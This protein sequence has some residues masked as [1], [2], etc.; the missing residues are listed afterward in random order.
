[1]A[2]DYLVSRL[3]G[4][5]IAG[6]LICTWSPAISV[7]VSAGLTTLYDFDSSVPQKGYAPR[8]QLASDSSGAFYGVTERGGPADIGTIF[9]L[10]KNA[11]GV[12]KHT[13]L[14]SFVAAQG[15]LPESGLSVGKDKAFYGTTP[16]GGKFGAGTIFRFAKTAKGWKLTVLHHFNAPAGEGFGNRGPLEFD[17]NGNIYGISTNSDGD[18]PGEGVVYQ[19]KKKARGGYTFKVLHAFTGGN[20]GKDSESGVTFGADG[21][22]YGTSS[23]STT[24]PG[25]I[26]K[27]TPNAAGT[28]WAHRVLH[29]FNAPANG[30]YPTGTLARDASGTLYGV[31]FSG[32]V[33]VSFVQRGVVFSYSEAEGFKVLYRFF[34]KPNDGFAPMPGPTLKGNFLYGTTTRGGATDDGVVYRVA[35]SNGNEVILHQMNGG[36]EGSS[37]RSPLLSKGGV[38]YGT[39]RSE[40]AKGGGSVFMFEP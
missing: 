18:N 23:G 25:T 31:T 15:G 12:W 39:L 16:R 40:G 30:R 6:A 34:S 32:G 35:K 3:V 5:A 20:G 28:K 8:G 9:M 36:A 38:F 7:A 11:K 14:Y 17:K 21:E 26:F 19:L 29:R 10:K 24:T 37:S 33:E 1:M 4:F 2:L 22:L 13:R 27:L